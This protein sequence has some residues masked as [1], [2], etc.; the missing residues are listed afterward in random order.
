M[1]KTREQAEPQITPGKGLKGDVERLKVNSTA[2]A[3]ELRAF[4]AGL[5]GRS[6]QEVLGIVSETGLFRGVAQATVG[7]IVLVAA[8]TV[9]PWAFAE[10][11]PDKQPETAASATAEPTASGAETPA[12]T[13]TE[14]AATPGQVDP[15]AAIRAMGEDEV[16]P[17][18]AAVDPL[19]NSLNNLLELK[20]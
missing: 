15:A 10:E 3:E 17:A 1:E 7:C 19:D 14:T 4:V 2:T 9:L 20:D 5:K 18:D 11:Q 12:A 13:G 16:K 6:P 8:L